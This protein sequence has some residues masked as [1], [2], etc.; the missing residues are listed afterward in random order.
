MANL[1]ASSLRWT[2][3]QKAEIRKHAKSIVM[4]VKQAVKCA[5]DDM[6]T[7]VEVGLPLYFDIPNFTV[8]QQRQTVYSLVIEELT[9]PEEVGGCNYS[10]ILRPGKDS[11]TL[12]ITWMSETDELMRK[13]EKEVIDYYKLSFQDRKGKQRPVSLT[14]DARLE[15]MK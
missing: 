1:T 9:A 5:H 7:S 8:A 4:D 13:H 11:A 6:Q 2:E 14:I 15:Q 3:T 10:V 12:F